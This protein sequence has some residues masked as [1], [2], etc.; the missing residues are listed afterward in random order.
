MKNVNA[1]PDLPVDL[2]SERLILASM[3]LQS[4]R[5]PEIAAK[6]GPEDFALE[7]HRRIW[8]K[9]LNLYEE[10]QNFD[11]VTLATE[12]HRTKELEAI[13]GLSFLLEL[14]NGMPLIPDL[15]GYVRNV[16]ECARL[17]RLAVFAQ[18]LMNRALDGQDASAE[19]LSDAERSLVKLVAPRDNERGLLTP[20]EIIQAHE[21]GIN[22]FLDPSKRILGVE[23]GFRKFDDMTGGLRPGELTILAARPSTGKTALAVNIAWYVA[24][25]LF[26]PVA[27]FSLE[28]TR[29]ALL[30]RAL[31]AAARV[32]SQR[33]RLGYLNEHE[34]NALRSAAKK[35]TGIP[36]LIDD[37]AEITLMDIR[38]K[39]TQAIQKYG[40]FALVVVDYL[41]LMAS[42]GKKEN[43]TVEVSEFSRGLKV[44]S[45]ELNTHFLVLSQLSRAVETRT[46]DHRP[47]LSDLRESGSIEQDA[48]VVAFIFRESM[49]KRDREDLRGTAELIL[50]KQRSGPIGRIDL[51]FIEAMTRFESKASDIEEVTERLPYGDA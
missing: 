43:R 36:L 11:R 25:R 31:C 4:S 5:L 9:M 20:L 49:Y 27:I 2:S 48:D 33:F 45:K 24:E 39:M 41:Q 50:A 37:S 42:K 35:A 44:L 47:Q 46:G 23:T 15:S 14:E 19:I 51:V 6:L 21:G 26:Q 8:A 34:R 22:S 30:T 1:L 13:G 17:R 18:D 12:L 28:M 16:E 7:V 38:A 40:P 10:A 32:D 29:Q 3:M